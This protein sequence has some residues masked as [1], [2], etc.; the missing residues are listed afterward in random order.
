[1]VQLHK[2]LRNYVADA[3]ADV[4]AE[5]DQLPY[6]TLLYVG[7]WAGIACLVAKCLAYIAATRPG[8]L[9]K[10]VPMPTF[11]PIPEVP[12]ACDEMLRRHLQDSGL[13]GG[14]VQV[15]LASGGDAD[16]EE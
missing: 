9:A 5:R 6:P 10:T 8:Q 11:D 12:T 1:M 3:T 7:R 4:A 15:R 16:A 2:H 13:F 14:L